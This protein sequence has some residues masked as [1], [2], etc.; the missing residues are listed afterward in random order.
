MNP[1]TSSVFANQNGAK[2]FVT[3]LRV[4]CM[5]SRNEA[6]TIYTFDTASMFLRSKTE[7][8]VSLTSLRVFLRSKTEQKCI[9]SSLR[10]FLRS[11]T[12]QKCIEKSNY[13][14]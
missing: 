13:R 3:S 4:V 10:V 14:T 9:V 11:K 2:V 12:E 1:V 6:D 5:R 7:Q 8:D